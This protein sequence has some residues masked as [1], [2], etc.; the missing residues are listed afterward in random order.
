M[1]Y[2][3]RQKVVFKAVLR[4]NSS[5]LCLG[6]D[7][8]KD[9]KAISRL[10]VFFLSPNGDPFHWLFMPWQC[11]FVFKTLSAGCSETV[12]SRQRF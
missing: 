3:L 6:M 1:D 9:G 8:F 4:K 10:T 12:Q 7:K 11:G 2:G 5:Q